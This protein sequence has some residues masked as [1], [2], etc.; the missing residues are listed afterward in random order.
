MDYLLFQ[1]NLYSSVYGV[2]TCSVCDKWLSQSQIMLCACKIICVLCAGPYI[3]CE[4]CQLDFTNEIRA[5]NLHQRIANKIDRP[6]TYN[7]DGCTYVVKPGDQH[8]MNC[9]YQPVPCHKCKEFVSKALMQDH[10]EETHFLRSDL[11]RD[12]KLSDFFVEDTGSRKIRCV[13][14]AGPIVYISILNV[15]NDGEFKQF[16][17]IY[18]VTLWNVGVKLDFEKDGYT[19]SCS[20]DS[21]LPNSTDDGQVCMTFIDI[22]KKK[23][24]DWINDENK[25]DITVIVKKKRQI[26]AQNKKTAAKKK[27]KVV[28]KKIHKE[29]RGMDKKVMKSLQAA[30]KQRAKIAYESL[31]EYN[32]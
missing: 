31:K 32:K 8:E 5:I 7:R 17:V 4:V 28:K 23:F 12:V 6:C 24:S 18:P 21:K 13:P 15:D 25:L 16:T 22:D 2:L 19:Y 27:A 20:T 1:N 10:F 26:N 3:K 11:N 14:N 30:H 29:K 9:E